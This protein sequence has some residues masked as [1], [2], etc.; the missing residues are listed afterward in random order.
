MVIGWG[1]IGDTKGESD[2]GDGKGWMWGG[3][4]DT[5]GGYDGGREW[6]GLDV[7]MYSLG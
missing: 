7:G 3:I 2:G 5:E 6:E 1:G 4:G